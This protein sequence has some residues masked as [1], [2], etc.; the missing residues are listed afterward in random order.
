MILG[1]RLWYMFWDGEQLDEPAFEKRLD[2]VLREIGDRGRGART[3]K[4]TLA[5]AS[6]GVPPAAA[7][8]PAPSAPASI[9]AAAPAPRTPAAVVSAVSRPTAETP[10]SPSFLQPLSAQSEQ[11]QLLHGG[12]LTTSAFETAGGLLVSEMVSFMREERQTMV[13]AMERQRQELEEHLAKVAT[14][15]TEAVSEEALAL[16]QARLE[17]LHS[18]KLL[19]DAELYSLEDAVAD[20]VELKASMAGQPITQAMIYAPLARSCCTASKLHKLVNLSASM[21]GDA[22]FARQI[23]RKFV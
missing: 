19:S 22:A 8:P 6:E 14:P 17:S 21:V 2:G 20:F 13:V 12:A 9:P 4:Q 7:L 18:A 1:S 11:P 15:P 10:F 5:V 23:R 3:A 16:L